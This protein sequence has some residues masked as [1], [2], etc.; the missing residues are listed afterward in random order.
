MFERMSTVKIEFKRET[1]I[2]GIDQPVPAGIYDVET[3]EELIPGLSFLAYRRV[4]TSIILP[5]SGA[6][7]GRQV[8][9]IDPKDLAEALA[10]GARAAAADPIAD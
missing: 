6:Y 9:D 2:P 7:L 1:R 4:R 10:A 3:V 5:A 8:F